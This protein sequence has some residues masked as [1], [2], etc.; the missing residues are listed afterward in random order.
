MYDICTVR[1][2]WHMSWRSVHVCSNTN[3]T[4]SIRTQCPTQK[5]PTAPSHRIDAS[6]TIRTASTPSPPGYLRPITRC[7]D[8]ERIDRC[9][10]A[11]TREVDR[12]FLPDWDF[13]GRGRTTGRGRAS[14]ID[15][16]T[17]QS[18]VGWRV[19]VRRT[20][21]GIHLWSDP[22]EGMN[23]TAEIQI[24]SRVISEQV[25]EHLY[26]LFPFKNISFF[27]EISPFSLCLF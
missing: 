13:R 16:R 26:P 27:L 20:D 8:P 25:R 24:E 22:R 3:S 2:Q 12:T 11:T 21:L 15:T 17:L 14:P 7:P 9:A 10:E 5:S 19:H 4:W 23:D 6:T 1:L 18:P